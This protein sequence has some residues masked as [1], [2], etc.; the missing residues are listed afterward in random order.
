MQYT[1]EDLSPVKKKITVTVPVEEGE[2]A[3]TAAIALYKTSVSL[4]GFRKGKVPAT[5]IEQR[6]FRE[7]YHEATTELV[8]VHINEIIS[9]GKFSPVSRIEFDGGQI[10]RGKE[11]VYSISFECMPEFTLPNYEGFEVEQEE[12][13]VNE[14]EVDAVIERLRGNMADVVTVGESRL[15][16][17]GDIAVLDFAAFDEQGTPVEGIAASNFELP[18]G[19]KQTLEDF[20][21]LICTLQPGES[22]EGPVRFPDDFFNAEFAGKTVIMKITLHAL[23]QRKLPELDDAF[24][25]KA[26]GLENM[27]KLRDNVRESYMTS[28]TALN[29]STAQKAILD[30]MLKL[31]EFP[32]PEGMVVSHVNVMFGDL[33][34]RLERQ[35]KNIAA[36]GKTEEELRAEVRPEAE[37]RTRAQILLLMAAREAELAVS[38]GEVDLQLRRMAMQSGE[39]YDT[40]KDYY[41]QNNLIFAL[42]DRIL[43][44]KAMDMMYDKAKITMVPPKAPTA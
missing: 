38:E 17:K 20:E 7:V 41:V 9:N 21:N 29:K 3:L 11:F 30:G 42:R 34:E 26:G 43:S 12:A 1:T 27:N 32:L 23:K 8:N 44:D 18:L 19:E 10:E 35:G 14:D 36:L 15:A 5:I 22:G 39:N 25:Q 31:V 37:M 33:Q 40:L 2:A 4:D 13:V 16:Q 6:F 24:A 28:R